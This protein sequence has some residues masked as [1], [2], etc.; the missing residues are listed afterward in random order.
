[1][2][3]L[4][5]AAVTV[6]R[7]LPPT[8]ELN[9]EVKTSMPLRVEMKGLRSVQFRLAFGA[10]PSNNLEFAIGRDKNGNGRLDFLEERYTFGY[11]CGN[12]IVKDTGTWKVWLNDEANEIIP[13]T[14]TYNVASNRLSAVWTID[15]S[16]YDPEWDMLRLTRRGRDP[17]DETA[18]MRD[19]RYGTVV[20]IR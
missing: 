17:T 6:L 1:M 13:V 3:A 19:S 12:W 15:R 16:L 10:S 8:T 2:S 14:A 20:I 5:I 4:L 7:F 11:D 9:T 18:S